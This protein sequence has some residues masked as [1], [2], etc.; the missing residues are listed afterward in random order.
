MDHPW[1]ADESP[2][3]SVESCRLRSERDNR[4]DLYQRRGFGNGSNITSQIVLPERST[5]IGRS[6]WSTD[7]YANA[8]FDEV[9]IWNKARSPQEFNVQLP[10]M[11]LTAALTS[12][13]VANLTWQNGGGMTPL[14]RYR[15]YRGSS[16]T[17]VSLFDSQLKRHTQAQVLRQPRRITTGSAQWTEPIRR[18]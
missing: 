12:S 9:R 8:I 16:L 10:P 11:N 3:E 14:M 17:T 7:S 1:I 6:N 5:Y 13:T 15:I 2:V 18:S 4:N